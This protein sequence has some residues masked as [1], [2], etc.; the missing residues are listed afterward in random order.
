V[1]ATPIKGNNFAIGRVYTDIC[2][3]LY[4]CTGERIT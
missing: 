1:V 2:V 4:T 3:K